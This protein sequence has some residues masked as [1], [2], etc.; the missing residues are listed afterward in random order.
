[1]QWQRHRSAPLQ[2]RGARRRRA[3]RR[4]RFPFWAGWL[5]LIAGAF[6]FYLVIGPTLPLSTGGSAAYQCRR[7]AYNCSDFRTRLAAQ[8]AFMACGGRRNDVHRL[9]EDGDGFACERLPLV[10]RFG[11]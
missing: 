2:G 5:T 7:N 3:A 4:G 11:G 1:M 9:D 10:P 8:A 6:T